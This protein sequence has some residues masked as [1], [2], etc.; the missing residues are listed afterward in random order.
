MKKLII[1]L[2][3]LIGSS[4]EAQEKLRVLVNDFPPL[5]IEENGR[6]EGFDIDL[7]YEIAKRIHVD[8]EY[9]KVEFQKIIKIVSQADNTIGIGGIT[10]TAEREKDIDFSHH[11]MVSDLSI[12]VDAGSTNFSYIKAFIIK[13]LPTMSY[14]GIFI[15]I[16]GHILWFSEKGRDA[17]N[18]RYFPGIFEGMWLSVTTMTTVGY[19]DYAPKRWSGRAVSCVIMIVGITFYGWAIANMSNIMITQEYLKDLTFEALQS[20]KFSTKKGSTSQSFLEDN[21]CHYIQTNSTKEA[22]FEL[23]NKNVDAVIF[24]QPVLKYYLQKNTDSSLHLLNNGVKRQYY[25][26]IMPTNYSMRE[27]INQALL[28]IREDGTYETIYEKWFGSN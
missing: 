21:G 14:L 27:K 6:F 26:I 11:Y 18:D 5:V 28:E 4:T 7:W 24:D 8:F 22:F 3:C 16:C 2:F 12:V 17:I 20:S 23:Y 19:G 1:L 13:M 9:K 10:I 25:G 15:L